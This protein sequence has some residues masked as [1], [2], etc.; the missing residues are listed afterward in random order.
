MNAKF[1]NLLLENKLGNQSEGR[2]R[3]I[4]NH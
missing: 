3:E 1:T 4:K 2:R